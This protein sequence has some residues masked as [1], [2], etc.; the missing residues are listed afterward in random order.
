MFGSNLPKGFKVRKVNE[1]GI[2][3]DVNGMKVGIFR[4]SDI[5]LMIVCGDEDG[6]RVLDNHMKLI[7][8]C[9]PIGKGGNIYFSYFN[10]FLIK[11][12]VNTDS[13]NGVS[14]E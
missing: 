8:E 9:K 1:T 2:D 13:R 4:A 11:K 3:I 14:S 5:E 10:K 7:G 6:F 12:D